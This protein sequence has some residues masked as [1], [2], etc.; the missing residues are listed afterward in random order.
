MSKNLTRKGLALGAIVALGSSLFAGAPAF[1]GV[2]SAKV[3]L[4][5]SAG[6]TYTTLIG[7]SFDLKNELDPTIKS[8]GLENKDA[9]KL[10]FLVS[11]ASAQK[12]SID[13]I[14][15]TNAVVGDSIKVLSGDTADFTGTTTGATAITNVAMS[16]RKFVAV[17]ADPATQSTD[18]SDVGANTL[19]ITSS[20]DST[21]PFSV[22]VQAFI[23]DNSNGEIDTFELTSPVRTLNF[24]KA[25]AATVTTAI[26]SS[27][28]GSTTLTG[29]VVIGNDVNN[30]SLDGQISIGFFKN[31]T[32]Y[33]MNGASNASVDTVDVSW[34]TTDSVL[35][36]S[37][38]TTTSTIGAGTYTA[39]AYFGVARSLLGTESAAAT[40]VAGTVTSAD[41]T[42]FLVAT[43]S[44]NVIQA[45]TVTT[46]VRSG[47]TGA[48]TFTSWVTNANAQSAVLASTDATIVKVAGVKVKVTLTKGST[49]TAGHEITSGGVKLTSTSGPVSYETTSS[50]TGAVAITATSNNGK[51]G[52]IYQVKVQVL[53]DNA[54]YQTGDLTD[55]TFADATIASI[56]VPAIVGNGAE[57]QVAKGGSVSLAYDIRDNFGAPSAVAGTYRVSVA[58]Q[59]SATGGATVSASAPVT[60]GKATVS[61]TDNTVTATGKYT[62]RATL[63]K[64]NDAGTAYASASQTVDTIINVGTAAVTAITV[65]AD[66]S[67]AVTLDASDFVNH[68]LRLDV[69]TKTFAGIGLDASN[70]KFVVTGTASSATGAVVPGASVT[71][72]AAGLQFVAANAGNNN[73]ATLAVGSITVRANSNGVY[74]VDAYSQKAGD[75]SISVTSGAATKAVI[76]KFAFA[77]TADKDSKLAITGPTQ[78]LPGRSAGY[79]VALT[80]K[81]GN[82]IKGAVTIAVTH[83][84]AG[85][86]TSAP[87]AVSA[88]DG[89]VGVT[90]VTQPGDTGIATITATFD[91]PN[92]TTDVV[93]SVNVNVGAAASAARIAGSTNRF[94]VTVDTNSL[95]R[96]VVV[97]VAD[98]TFATLRGSTAKRTY[99]VRAP[100]GTHKVTVFVGG[101]L[102]ATKTIVVR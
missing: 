54:G 53:T 75:V 52:D 27:T 42:D 2:E 77:T 23:D 90:L 3:T 49:F 98:R 15:S 16:T 50:A 60:A 66:A 7:A 78:F 51:K 71:I 1:A 83:S 91:V 5:P 4:A 22:T 97:K 44:A 29:T 93:A 20:T 73:D 14:G 39:K 43:P 64:L 34:D 19:R 94:F 36:N 96:N 85:Y 32:A 56:D 13:L 63:E 45:S 38:Y 80:D 10:T 65:P 76:A 95:A 26:T 47:H 48:V 68:D 8:A 46:T 59:G 41:H 82:A 12:L 58:L 25:S 70:N 37:Q 28:I 99:S 87:T 102:V 72:S 100:K 81:F 84:G 57:T 9:G 21:D 6:T 17:I 11:N 61:F 88:V 55:V 62:V 67:T 24:I 86:L 89:R 69:N 101:K 33:P 74:S 30:R 35:T 40:P 79:V 18:T 92:S 31:G